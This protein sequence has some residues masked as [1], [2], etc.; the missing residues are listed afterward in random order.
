M[1]VNGAAREGRGH[2]VGP[3]TTTPPRD[4]GGAG[5]SARE[6][7]RH[8]SRVLSYLGE[9]KNRTHGEFLSLELVLVAGVLI[10]RSKNESGHQKE[11]MIGA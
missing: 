4:S 2:R 6:S 8:K 10:N 3:A 1:S 11:M 5:Q 7:R 9:E